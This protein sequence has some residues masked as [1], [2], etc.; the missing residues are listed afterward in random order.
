VIKELNNKSIEQLIQLF[1]QLNIP[2]FLI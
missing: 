1:N 2:S